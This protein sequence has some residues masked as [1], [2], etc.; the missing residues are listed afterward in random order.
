MLSPLTII[1]SIAKI[2]INCY[3]HQNKSNQMKTTTST[4]SKP[5]LSSLIA[6]CGMNCRLCRAY[7]RE[8]N[9]CPGCR[10][11]DHPKPKTRAQCR[12]KQCE[13]LKAADLKYCSDC[14]KSPC[15]RLKHLDTRYKTKYGMSMIDNLTNIKQSGIRNFIKQEKVRWGCPKCGEVICVHKESCINCNHTWR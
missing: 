7:I 12:I 4:K 15:D 9:A 2:P 10:I 11:D 3:L 14:S 8:K 1:K 6:P 5:M 13:M